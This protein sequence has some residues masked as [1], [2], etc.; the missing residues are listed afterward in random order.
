M[1]F[2][3]NRITGELEEAELVS[4]IADTDL[5]CFHDEWRPIFD[6][7]IARIQ[8]EGELTYAA[9]VEH[10][11]EDAH[12]QWAA[13]RAQWAGQ[14][15]WQTYA[16]RAAGRTQAMMAVNLLHTARLPAHAGQHLAYV[17]WL[18]IAPWNRPRLS[19]AP[20]YSGCGS[21]LITEAVLVSQDNDWQG[22]VGL[23]SL[24]GA[25]PFYERFG[26]ALVELDELAQ[27]LPYLELTATAA[28]AFLNP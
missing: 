17:S 26:F 13:K 3:R 20:Q 12:W 5:A 15:E 21:V 19:D 8:E 25:Q 2:L 1:A 18:A 10:N 6:A 23:H 9:L 11:C 7:R 14:L 22:R 4:P 24:P 28:H 16:L 27:G